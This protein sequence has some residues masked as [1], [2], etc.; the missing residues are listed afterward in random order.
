[1]KVFKG[2]GPI[3]SLILSDLKRRIK[4]PTTWIIIWL[5]LLLS[6]VEIE[7]MKAERLDRQFSGE[8]NIELEI[9]DIRLQG[10]KYWANFV[11]KYTNKKRVEIAKKIVKAEF[12]EDYRSYNRYKAFYSLIYAKMYMSHSDRIRSKAAEIEMKEIWDKVSD[13]THFEDIS[14]YFYGDR[15]Y[16]MDFFNIYQA[17]F[18]YYLYTNDLEEVYKDDIN[19]VSFLYR[20]LI[21]MLPLLLIV[22]PILLTH[23]SINKEVNSGSARL[24]LTQGISRWKYYI[25]KYISGVIHILFLAYIPLMFISVMIG[26]KYGFVSFKYPVFYYPLGFK[27]LTPRYNYVEGLKNPYEYIGISR[28]PQQSIKEF[29][30]ILLGDEIIPFYNFLILNI[31]FTLLFVLFAVALSELV[32]ALINNEIISFGLVLAIFIS[33]Y[34]L[35]EPYTHERNYNISPFTMNNSATIINGSCNVTALTSF[36]ILSL[37]TILLLTIGM[38]YFKKKNI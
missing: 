28:L 8:H 20:Y 23:N 30:T 24:V 3:I 10:S 4:S 18:Y 5:I 14:T 36:L 11:N 16:L 34:K 26:F 38:L 25:S 9:L 29:E 2:G 6:Y 21:D 37:F 17:K 33:G 35:S 22:F 7:N 1:M 19:N 15:A 32:S 12:N 27:G 31:L 13:G